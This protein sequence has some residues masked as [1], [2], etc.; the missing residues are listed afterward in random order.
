MTIIAFSYMLRTIYD[1]TNRDMLLAA[2]FRVCIRVKTEWRRSTARTRLAVKRQPELDP[3]LHAHAV[4]HTHIDTTLPFR[5]AVLAIAAN[6][7]CITLV[8]ALASLLQI[9]L[10]V[11]LGLEPLAGRHYFS[12]NR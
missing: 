1:P 5:A 8:R 2:V 12:D 3:D 7:R 11:L 9:G 4:H 6:T 10:V